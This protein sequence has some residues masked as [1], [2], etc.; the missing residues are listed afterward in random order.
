MGTWTNHLEHKD[1][2]RL[3]R[4]PPILQGKLSAQGKECECHLVEAK[5]SNNK[6]MSPGGL[7]RGAER[8]SKTT[9]MSHGGTSNLKTQRSLRAPFM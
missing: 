8:S 4:H 5:A 9:A 3:Q 2:F 1:W 6:S 7:N